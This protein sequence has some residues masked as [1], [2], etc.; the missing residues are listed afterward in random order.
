MSTSD[1]AKL[2][3]YFSLPTPVGEFVVVLDSEDTVRAAGFNSLIKLIRL[4][5]QNT[6][7]SNL[8]ERVLHPYKILLKEYF[9]GEPVD[10]QKITHQQPGTDFQQR[11]WQAMSNIPY[12][13]TSTYKSIATEAGSARA[14]RAAGS[15]CAHNRIIV[16]VPCHRVLKSDG[17]A[18]NYYY[19]HKIKNFLLKLEQDGLELHG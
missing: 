11:A 2:T 1:D 13:T 16:I 9:A 17:T 10:L 7:P 5:D 12:G 6:K 14:S 3:S 19:G 15:A 4:V 18:G 8:E